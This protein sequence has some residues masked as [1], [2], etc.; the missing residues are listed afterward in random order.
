M[1]N[2]EREA[3]REAVRKEY[4]AAI[5]AAHAEYGTATN[6]AHAKYDRACGEA[7]RK[8]DAAL[9]ELVSA[10]ERRAYVAD[11]FVELL[12]NH[13]RDALR[14]FTFDGD[15]EKLSETLANT[16]EMWR[17]ENKDAEGGR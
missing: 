10:E 9:A 11:C 13:C 15:A 6:A 12:V 17:R 5:D 3:R 1:T 14:A 2:E 16:R 4:G 8:R 7:Y